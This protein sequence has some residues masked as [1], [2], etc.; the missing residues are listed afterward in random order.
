MTSDL[1]L[2]VL[3]ADQLL[4]EPSILNAVVSLVNTTYLDHKVFNGEL[5]FSSNDQL[6][7]ELESGLCA[8]LLEKDGDAVATASIKL[9]TKQEKEIIENLNGFVYEVLTLWVDFGL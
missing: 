1:Q 9:W 7:V 6:C 8:V 2:K 3:S 5:R 4:K